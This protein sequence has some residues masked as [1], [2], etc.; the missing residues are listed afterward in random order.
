MKTMG[1]L[2]VV[3]LDTTLEREVREG[4][5]AVQSEEKEDGHRKSGGRTSRQRG[6]R[7]QGLEEGEH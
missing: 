2:K 1:P 7:C 3:E 5:G 6:G 4:Y